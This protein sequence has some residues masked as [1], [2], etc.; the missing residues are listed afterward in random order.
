[1]DFFHRHPTWNV[2][3]SCSPST[4]QLNLELLDQRLA[5][6]V[7]HRLNLLIGEGAVFAA[8][9]Q[10]ECL[11][12]LVVTELT[13]FEAID[14]FHGFQQRLARLADGLQQIT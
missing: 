8:I 3:C 10:T 1:M 4:A 2:W 5:H 11:A 13:A 9:P 7:M 12:A 14:Q 6:L